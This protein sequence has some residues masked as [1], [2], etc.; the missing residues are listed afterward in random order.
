M[1]KR[2]SVTG[3]NASGSANKTL[4]SVIGSTAIRPIVYDVVIGCSATP[5]DIAANFQVL[6][7]TAQGTAG[8]N[9]TPL[10]LDPGDPAAVST[11]GITHSAEPTYAATAFLNIS[12]NQRA[13]FRWVA[14]PGGELIGSAVA[15]NGVG[16]KLVAS[17]SA[18]IFDGMVHWFE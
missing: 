11:A 2:Y 13:T 10:A 7:N 1:A 14:A 17:G 4:I 5:G 18:L 12:M 16:L 6:R 15:S 3:S 9:P 8:T